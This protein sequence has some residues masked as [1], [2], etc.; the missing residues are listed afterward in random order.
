MADEAQVDWSEKASVLGPAYDA[1]SITP[2]TPFANGANGNLVVRA[3]Y[4]GTA[5]NVVL[6]TDRGNIAT[7]LNLTT[8]QILQVRCR[9]VISTST[10]ASGIVGMY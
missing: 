7:F 9:G 1:F 4:I 3:L 6:T 8:G 5:G 10:T 2:G